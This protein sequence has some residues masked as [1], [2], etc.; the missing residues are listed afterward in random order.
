MSRKCPNCTADVLENAKFCIKCGTKM[1]P[2]VTLGSTPTP[3]A[4]RVPPP[5]SSTSNKRA[6]LRD[7]C[8]SE[9][10]TLEQAKIWAEL[11]AMSSDDSIQKDSRELITKIL[12]DQLAGLK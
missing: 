7:N 12:K 11:A 2:N 1:P 4:N 6:Y 9:T 5:V 3:F 8:F 10:P